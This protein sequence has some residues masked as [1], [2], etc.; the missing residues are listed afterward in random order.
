M[1]QCHS[2][3]GRGGERQRERRDRSWTTCRGLSEAVPRSWLLLEELQAFREAE[4]LEPPGGE[5]VRV[6][7]LFPR[8]ST[9]S[10][11]SHR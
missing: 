8:H 7:V 11:L 6:G 10:S 2:C 9:R 1:G 4:P 5:P 3:A